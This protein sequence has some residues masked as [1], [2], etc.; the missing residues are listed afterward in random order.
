MMKKHCTI[1]LLVMLA[2]MAVAQTGIA[3]TGRTTTLNGK[4]Y[5]YHIVENGQSVFSI[6]R[7]YG[8]HYSAA[9]LRSDLQHVNAGDTVWL[10][11][12]DQSRAAVKRAIGMEEAMPSKEGATTQTIKVEKGQTLY[13][14]AKANGTTVERIQELNPGITAEN[15]KTGQN[16]LV[17]V[18]G[19]PQKNAKT[20]N[21]VA[22]PAKGTKES[23]EVSNSGKQKKSGNGTPNVSAN[24][25]GKQEAAVAPM[26]VRPRIGND[27]VCVAVMMPLHL[28][29]MGEISTTK[30]DVDQRGKKDYKSFEFIQFYEGLQIALD[31]LAQSGVNVQL[32]VV[33]I[34]DENENTIRKAY[35][36]HNVAN[37]DLLIAL[38][39]RRGFEVAAQLARNDRLFVVNPL[40]TRGEI[41]VG[42]PYV[43]KYMPS[44]AGKITALVGALK[45]QYGGSRVF[46]VG[47]NAKNEATARAEWE[48]QLKA[49]NIHNTYYDWSKQAQLASVLKTENR[50][51]VVNLYDRDREKNRIQTNLLLNRM[52]AAKTRTPVLVTMDNLVRDMADADF[53]Q[54]QNCNYHLCYPTYLDYT[55][56]DHKAF[57]DAFKERYR[58]EPNGEFA[59]AAHDILLY[60]ATAINQKGS[61]WWNNPQLA[62]PQGMLFPM[63][64]LRE[65][66]G[67][68]LEN[69]AVKAYEMI[70][71]QLKE[72]K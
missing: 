26:E 40:S 23:A 30:F 25:S 34:D 72:V 49:N 58:T 7:A 53:R 31:E 48:R 19:A 71:F 44:D 59:A 43:V 69:H 61:D 5:Y 4:K 17:P 15:L 1:L 57:I 60:F 45:A 64:L 56:P 51:V 37:S 41:V 3:P 13:S 36:S 18:A 24:N 20:P 50:P 14:I 62:A 32:N 16:L 55:N 39:Q 35:A 28:Q 66:D 33:D 54:L 2:A 38:L 65:G 12:N 70:D 21:E 9:V 46:L 52:N 67:N 47:S 29:R 8:L 68:G 11:V 27:K 6:A 10:P 42:N 22:K 63:R